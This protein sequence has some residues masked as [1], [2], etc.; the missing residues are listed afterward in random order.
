MCTQFVDLRMR[1]DMVVIERGGRQPT[2]GELYSIMH[3][4]KDV[5]F[6][7]PKVKFVR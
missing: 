6:T 1:S 2:R 5:T 7:D 4:K 3:E